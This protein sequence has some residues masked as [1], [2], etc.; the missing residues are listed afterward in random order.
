MLNF[1]TFGILPVS[2]PTSS[3]FL[4]L[5]PS[6]PPSFFPAKIIKCKSFLNAVT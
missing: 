1:S 6:I 5:P 4:L 3:L 2:Y